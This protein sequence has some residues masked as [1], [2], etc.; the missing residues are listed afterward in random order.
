MKTHLLHARCWLLSCLLLI[1]ALS[2]CS[3]DGGEKG[4]QTATPSS[5]N[6]HTTPQASGIQLGPQPCPA[7]VQA[8]AHWEALV[9]TSASQKVGGVLCAYLMGA[10]TLQAVVKVH[11]GGTESLLDIA[12]YT[13]IT[14]TNPTRLFRLNGLPHGDV[15]ISNYNTLLTAEIDPMPSQQA[16]ALPTPVQQDL[17]REFKWSDSAGTV[18][19]LTRRVTTGLPLEGEGR[20]S[21]Q[22]GTGLWHVVRHLMTY[23]LRKCLALLRRRPRQ[24]VRCGFQHLVALVN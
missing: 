18:G 16:G 4:N 24:Q 6:G 12:V 23:A 11:Y 14:G 15:G 5:G 13:N 2:A 20:C 7:A 8:A 1:L 22:P 3:L 21:I 19:L 10:P 17:Y 9:A